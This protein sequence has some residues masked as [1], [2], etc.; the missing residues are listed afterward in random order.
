MK[1]VDVAETYFGRKDD[2]KVEVVNISRKHNYLDL[3]FDHDPGIYK[4]ATEELLTE[5]AIAIYGV[6]PGTGKGD[7]RVWF[8]RLDAEVETS[9]SVE[10]SE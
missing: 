7:L 5:H 8:T 6:Q 3:A 9:V 10:V 4:N 1:P 2:R